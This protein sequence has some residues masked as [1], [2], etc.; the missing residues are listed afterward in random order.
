MG[1]WR[2]A[3]HAFQ[4]LVL[5]NT[6]CADEEQVLARLTGGPGLMAA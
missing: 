5:E 4:C 2:L 1:L 6:F 3:V